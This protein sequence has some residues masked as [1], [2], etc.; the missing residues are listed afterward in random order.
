[1]GGAGQ[2]TKLFKIQPLS[3]CDYGDAA[4]SPTSKTSSS[5]ILVPNTTIPLVSMMG[6]ALR[7]SLWVVL[8]LQSRMRVMVCLCTLMATR[9]HLVRKEHLIHRLIGFHA[10][11][12]TAV[13]MSFCWVQKHPGLPVSVRIIRVLLTSC[14]L[15]TKVHIIGASQPKVNANDCHEMKTST[16]LI[17]VVV[18]LILSDMEEK[19][20]QDGLFTD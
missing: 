19:G 20:G 8:F 1:M 10:W 2:R 4:W 18:M 11:K 16:A 12:V 13:F 14:I 7:S 6:L 9:C 15:G 3:L 5:S 17:Q